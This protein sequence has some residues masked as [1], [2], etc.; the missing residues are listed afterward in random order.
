MHHDDESTCV[1]TREIS[2]LLTYASGSH[3]RHRK[4]WILLAFC[5]FCGMLYCLAQ[6]A[7]LRGP[8][9]LPLFDNPALQH[10][11][12]NGPLMPDDCAEWLRQ[13]RRELPC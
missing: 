9:F 13:T 12:S 10:R 8:D 2:G 3:C 5:G 1:T 11:G 7:E 4:C 6:P